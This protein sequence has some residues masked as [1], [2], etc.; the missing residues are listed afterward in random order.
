[1]NMNN[2]QIKQI[3]A[4]DIAL[5]QMSNIIGTGVLATVR[6]TAARFGFSIKLDD[7]GL[8]PTRKNRAN[9][10]R[11]A[12]VSMLGSSQRA[13]LLPKHHLW[14]K[15]DGDG[16]IVRFQ[17]AETTERRI[18]ALFPTK[19]AK[20]RAQ[21]VDSSSTMLAIPVNGMTFIPLRS[22]ERWEMEYAQAKRDHLQSAEN[23]VNNYDRL[24]QE[25]LRHYTLIAIDIYNRILTTSPD[26][27]QR[28]D[29]LL[30]EMVTITPLAWTRKWK[31]A[32][33]RAWPTKQ[34]ILDAYTVEAKFFWAPA[35]QENVPQY[36]EANTQNYLAVAETEAISEVWDHQQATKRVFEEIK[37][38]VSATQR[39]QSHEL[40][41]SYVQTILER[42]EKVFGGFLTFLET[43]KRS[44]STRQLNSVLKVAE[45]IQSLGSGVS[46]LS[47]IVQQAKQIEQFIEDAKN[48]TAQNEKSS[49]KKSKSDQ[50]ASELPEI[51][52][53]ALETIR[54]EAE[55]MIGNEARRSIVSASDEFVTDFSETSI[56]GLATAN[57]SRMIVDEDSPEFHSEFLLNEPSAVLV[58]NDDSEGD[59]TSSRRIG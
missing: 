45:M 28:Y 10:T 42:T 31:S 18:R 16:R 14:L 49:L 53:Q 37:S 4:N 43:E 3:D 39:S 30:R 29:Y 57:R 17:T 2:E 59:M 1:M 56:V 50:F 32:V 8:V 23:L 48:S 47:G 34:Q 33:L 35:A 27:L 40:A 21:T 5:D 6:I 46:G 36:T 9:R 11:F 41:V 25:S 38:H 13:S 15:Q 12:I 24:K 7:L 51:I 26:T 54:Q 19:Y 55:A 52:T 44:A 20:N 22:W 58:K